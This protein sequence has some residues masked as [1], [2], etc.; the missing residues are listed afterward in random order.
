MNSQDEYTI[1]ELV[2]MNTQQMNNQ[3][4]YTVDEQSG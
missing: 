4:E 2:K 3:D 1:D